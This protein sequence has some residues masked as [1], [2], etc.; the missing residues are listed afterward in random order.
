MIQAQ[1]IY[2]KYKD[3]KVLNGVNINVKTAEIVSIVGASGAGKT[4]LL[5][6]LSS[7]ELADQNPNTSI[8]VNGID[9]TKLNQ[10]Q[11]SKFR[12]EN[13]SRIKREDK[14]SCD[15]N[16]AILLLEILDDMEH[17]SDQMADIAYSIIEIYD[18]EKKSEKE[19][20]K[21]E[22]E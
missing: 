9:I 10:K 7:L 4:T 14:A 15:P 22:T 1:N 12:N 20:E 11:L 6:I 3:L 5:Q 16:S 18:G 2:K 19:T 21:L 13:I 17:V 8:E